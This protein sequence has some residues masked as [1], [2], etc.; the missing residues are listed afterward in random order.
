MARQDGQSLIE[1]IMII[2]VVVTAVYF[3][4]PALKRG[5]QRVIKVTADQ[6]APQQNAEQDYGPDETF[7]VNQISSSHS[8]NHRLTYD[9]GNGVNSVIN[10]T[11][12]SSSTT[13]TNDAI[14]N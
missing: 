10:E 8:I 5:T 11:S 1:Y 12:D 13:V 2:G 14:A 4:A 6:M 9:T 7:M 3:M